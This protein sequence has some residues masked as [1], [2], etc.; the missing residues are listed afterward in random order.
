MISKFAMRLYKGFLQIRWLLR[1]YMVKLKLTLK[2][3]E[4]R[5]GKGS[6]FPSSASLDGTAGIGKIRIGD[7]VYIGRYSIIHSKELVS[8]GSN[9]LI[10]DM[11]TIRDSDH[12]F[13]QLDKPI[14]EQGFDIAPVVIEDNV[15]LA[16]KVTVT[17][18]VRIGRNSII[19]ANAVVITDVPPDTIFG[20]IP[21]RELRRR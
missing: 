5:I 18:G 3:V 15:W 9:C 10:A 2:G 11:V 21:A 20:G 16:A 7:K 13:S 17:K 14:C 19:A 1:L 4:F 8:I 6:F 12:C